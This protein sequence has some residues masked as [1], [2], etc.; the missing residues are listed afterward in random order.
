MPQNVTSLSLTQ[1]LTKRHHPQTF[2][3]TSY[4]LVENTICC[5]LSNIIYVRYEQP[6]FEKCGIFCFW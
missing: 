3:F 6:D 5:I 4:S 1:F 2:P